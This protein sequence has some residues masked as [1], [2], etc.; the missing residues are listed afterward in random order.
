MVATLVLAEWIKYFNDKNKKQDIFYTSK[1][2]NSLDTLWALSL[3]S[4][5]KFKNSQNK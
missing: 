3:W 1:E 5:L 4:R 2:D